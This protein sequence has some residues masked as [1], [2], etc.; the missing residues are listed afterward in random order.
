MRLSHQTGA[1]ALITPSLNMLQTLPMV[2]DGEK[3]WKS[4]DFLK[5]ILNKNHFNVSI[6]PKK[7]NS[8][9]GSLII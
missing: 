2:V 5:W 6:F 9:Q 1:T 4:T 7:M 8:N 3:C